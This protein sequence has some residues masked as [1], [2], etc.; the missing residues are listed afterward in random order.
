LGFEMAGTSA[1]YTGSDEGD[2]EIA[3]SCLLAM[4][5]PLVGVLTVPVSSTAPCQ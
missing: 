5:F 1:C 2:I 3:S 4:T